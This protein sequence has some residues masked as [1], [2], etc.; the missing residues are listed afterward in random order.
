MKTIQ[1]L[2]MLTG[3]V[4]FSSCTKKTPKFIQIDKLSEKTLFSGNTYGYSEVF[5]VENPPEDKAIRDSL[6]LNYFMKHRIDFCA[7]DG[8]I[9][10]Y[11]MSFFRK[12]SCTSYY[13]DN[14]EDKRHLIAEDCEDYYMGMFYYERSK[15][16][17]DIWTCTYP[18]G[19]IDT[20]YC[21]SQQVEMD[22]IR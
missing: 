11:A 9:H 3:L 7:L 8:D 2:F 10:K 21:V 1:L 12:N 18:E 19:I 20:V 6:K 5:L 16:N 22:T 14:E 15:E 13:M 17:P 4:L